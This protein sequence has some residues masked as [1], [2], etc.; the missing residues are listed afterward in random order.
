VRRTI[1]QVCVGEP[2][3]SN[4]PYVLRY[5]SVCRAGPLAVHHA[6]EVFRTFSF[7]GMHQ[8]RPRADRNRALLRPTERRCDELS[9]AMEGGTC[10]IRLGRSLALSWTYPWS[11]GTQRLGRSLWFGNVCVRKF[12]TTAGAFAERTMPRWRQH[13]GTSL[14]RRASSAHVFCPGAVIL[15]GFFRT[16]RHYRRRRVR[17]KLPG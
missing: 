11:I 12:S 16:A 17:H 9:D 1:Q 7:C 2:S 8:L 15:I 10:N 5:I 13:T 14:A 4:E 3:L 6:M